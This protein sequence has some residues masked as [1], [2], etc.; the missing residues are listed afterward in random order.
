MAALNPQARKLATGT[1]ELTWTPDPTCFG[2]RFYRDRIP[3]AKSTRATQPRTTFAPETDGQPHTYS[4]ARATEEPMESTVFPAPPAPVPAAFMSGGHFVPVADYPT[5]AGLGWKFILDDCYSVADAR[6]KCDAA[7]ANGLKL[8]V[9]PYPKPY[10]LNGQQGTGATWT[11]STVGQDIIRYLASRSE[12]LALFVYN[13]PYWINPLGGGS[14]ANGTIPIAD[15]RS[16]RTAIRAVAPIP[17]Y[18]DIGIPAAWA[19]GGWLWAAHSGIG[20]KYADQSGIADYVG[21][22]EYPFRQDGSYAK[23]K[24]LDALKREAAFVTGKMGARPVWLMQTHGSP[25]EGVRY[26]ADGELADYVRACRAGFPADALMSFYTWG[27]SGLYGSSI[28]SAH[29]SQWPT[30]TA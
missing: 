10:S 13:E 3:V 30:V 15:L 7:K 4:V 16:L 1:I 17:V 5:V 8:I 21:C 14:S 20:N 24:S 2:Y 18:H 28:L 19:P 9:G 6:V 27:K 25:A 26:P 29:P 22:W 23:Q 11:I 12:V